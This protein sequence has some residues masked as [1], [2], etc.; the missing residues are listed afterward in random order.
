[1]N[2][3]TKDA[4]QAAREKVQA[5]EDS[6]K[7]FPAQSSLSLYEQLQEQRVLRA[8]ADEEDEAAWAGRAGGWQGGGSF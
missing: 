2:R 8:E 5:Q 6:A 3:D 7:D 1:M 4:W